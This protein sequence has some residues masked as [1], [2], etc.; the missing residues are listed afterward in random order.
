MRTRLLALTLGLFLSFIVLACNSKPAD[1]T[2]S[3]DNSTTT[4]SGSEKAA[5][6]LRRVERVSFSPSKANCRRPSAERHGCPPGSDITSGSSSNSF[7]NDWRVFTNVVVF[8]LRSY[9][10]IKEL[11]FEHRVDLQLNAG[12][13]HEIT[14]RLCVVTFELFEFPKNPVHAFVIFHQHVDRVVFALRG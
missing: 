9:R 12:G 14:H 13:L 8:D 10:R 3:N 11:L 5:S 6:G 2:A 7:R 4:S 1:S